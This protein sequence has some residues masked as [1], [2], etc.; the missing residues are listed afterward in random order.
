MLGAE[1]DLISIRRDS[2]WFCWNR[3]LSM[4]PRKEKAP[5]G[6]CGFDEA[7]LLYF[8]NATQCVFDALPDGCPKSGRY[9]VSAST[10]R[11]KISVS[12]HLKMRTPPGFKTRKHSE[13][14]AR[15][16]AGQVFLSNSP[17]FSAIH[18][19]FPPRLMICG[20]S[21]TTSEKKLSGKTNLRKSITASGATLMVAPFVCNVGGSVRLSR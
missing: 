21:N 4:I 14:P 20:G 3:P 15:I 9:G 5:C 18:D 2:C 10:S 11:S 16:S 12:F 17:Y 19:L 6:A 8:I 1:D 7:K 13:K